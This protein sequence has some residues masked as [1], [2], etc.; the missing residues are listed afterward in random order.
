MAD[1]GTLSRLTAFWDNEVDLRDQEIRRLS[2]VNA[3]IIQK[4]RDLKLGVIDL[5][6]IQILEDGSI[7]ILDPPVVDPEQASRKNGTK[8]N[9]ELATAAD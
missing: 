1:A 8:D 7:Q 6:L 5:S 4:L 3:H 2:G 9:K